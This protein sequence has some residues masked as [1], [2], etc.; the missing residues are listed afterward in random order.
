MELAHDPL[1]AQAIQ[2]RK[3]NVAK[4]RRNSASSPATTH[5]IAAPD[6]RRVRSESSTSYGLSSMMSKRVVNCPAAGAVAG[7]GEQ[8]SAFIRTA[9]GFR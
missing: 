6:R 3:R 7:A 9:A 1:R 4:A 2:T 8:E 5:S